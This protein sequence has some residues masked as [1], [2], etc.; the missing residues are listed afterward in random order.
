MRHINLHKRPEQESAWEKI[1]CARY[2]LSREREREGDFT[3]LHKSLRSRRFWA[4]LETPNW[5]EI[6][7]SFC[8]SFLLLLFLLIL[9]LLLILCCCCCCCCCNRLESFYLCTRTCCLCRTICCRLPRWQLICRHALRN[10]K[11]F[12]THLTVSYLTII[13]SMFR[14]DLYG[15]FLLQLQWGFN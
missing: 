3:H 15:L 13:Y 10:C 6:R 1:M 12:S 8:C 5:L 4:R 14:R 9:L 7:S 11:R 2:S